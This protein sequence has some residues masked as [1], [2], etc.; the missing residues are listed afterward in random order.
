M[1]PNVQD[2]LTGKTCVQK[3]ARPVDGQSFEGLIPWVRQDNNLTRFKALR[4]LFE[5]LY[6]RSQM[7]CRLFR[8]DR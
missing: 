6:S 8:L 7:Y 2:Y 1:G 5:S 4:E 3:R